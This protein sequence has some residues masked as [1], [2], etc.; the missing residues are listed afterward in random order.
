MNPTLSHIPLFDELEPSQTILLAGAGGGYDIAS[1]IPLYVALTSMGKNVILAN[2]S[3]SL[4]VGGEKI[5]S[6]CYKV[7]ADTRG[8]D[9]FPEK[10]ICE[11]F[12]ER[13][14]D[15]S[16]YCFNVSGVQPIK[17]AYEAIIEEHEID[18][19]L[20]VDGGTDSLMR[21]DEAGLGTPVE[22]MAS[23]AAAYSI[24]LERKYLA[25]LGFG[26]DHFHGVCHAQFLENVAALSQTGDYLGTIS[27][28][29][30]MPEAEVF[31]SMV[32]YLNQ[33][34][35]GHP[36]IVANSINS[37][38]Q[39]HYGDFH[40]TKRTRGS[41]LWINP[42]MCLYWCFGL[43]AVAE[44]LL[45]LDL[46]LPTRSHMEVKN[47]IQEFMRIVGRKKWEHIPL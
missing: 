22:D 35:A 3:F 19:L 21:G 39:G 14:E 28:L 7:N 15:L 46:L 38:L 32:A 16:M 26:I 40:A 44:R 17:E 30:Q 36:S 1:G 23:I 24:P 12:R 27:L 5:S 18:T 4:L 31:S 20:L 29:P 6:I 43:S 41:Q 9:Y 45:Y 33:K 13:G 37:A 25:C 34:M 8:G 10:Y 11:W 2:L 42:L 47:A